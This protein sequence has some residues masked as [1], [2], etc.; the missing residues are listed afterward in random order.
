[1]GYNTRVVAFF[2]DKTEYKEE[3]KLL[4][5]AAAKLSNRFN[6]RIGIVT[7][8]NLI[9][10]MK[11]KHG[12]FFLLESSS[13]DVMV[14][15]RYDGAIFKTNLAEI[16]PNEYIFW[17]TDK[18]TKPVD[19]LSEAVFQMTAQAEVL[20]VCIVFVDFS[21]PKVKSDSSALI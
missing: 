7:D 5:K 13:K 11:Q 6:L 10:Q 1:M 21:K 9:V 20:S 3:I 8:N 12:E 2:Y 4:K 17:I 18:S 15:K 19:K 16:P 14:L